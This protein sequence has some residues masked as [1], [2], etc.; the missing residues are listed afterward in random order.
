MNDSLDLIYF[1]VYDANT[2]EA[3]MAFRTV[4]AP[5]LKV[6]GRLVFRVC[7]QSGYTD[8]M[9]FTYKYIEKAEYESIIEMEIL[10]HYDDVEI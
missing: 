3:L 5:D 6:I 10:P 1:V 9:E 8:T 4:A 2:D 7:R